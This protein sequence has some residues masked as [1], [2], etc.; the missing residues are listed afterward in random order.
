MPHKHNPIACSIT[1]AA[2]NRAP[3]MVAAFLSGMVQEHER[4]VGGW[5]AEWSTISALI[6]S[7]GAALALMVEVA[8]GL[9]VDVARMRENIE[10]TG[11]TIFAEKALM[12][13]AVSMGR[14]EAHRLLEEATRRS[15][16]EA[17]RLSEVLADMPDVARLLPNAALRDLEKPEMYLGSAEEFR[18]R[19]LATEKE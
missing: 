3:S 19:L 16:V 14:D 18:A 9:T 11:G 10:A 2:A 5:H 17:R 15:I 1:L 8:E 13:L 7:T 4:G 6:Q 12:L